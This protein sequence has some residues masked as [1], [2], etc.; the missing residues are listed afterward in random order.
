MIRLPRLDTPTRP[1]TRRTRRVV[2]G[3]IAVVALLAVIAALTPHH[4]PSDGL[5][6]HPTVTA[7][8]PVRSAVGE[9]SS[10]RSPAAVAR[11]VAVDV[12]AG[13]TPPRA[14][15]T[16]ALWSTLGSPQPANPVRVPVDGATV[17]A[18]G[19]AGATE[20]YVVTVVPS[21]VQPVAVDVIVT[22]VGHDPIVESLPGIAG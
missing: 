7:L 14:D 5:G 3:F 12:V 2:A 1:P 9:V 13:V 21:D 6:G 16:A 10:A 17:A 18:A 19:T 15:V 8:L 22:T 11:T 4:S 20:M